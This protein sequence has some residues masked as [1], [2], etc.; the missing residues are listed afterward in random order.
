MSKLNENH[1]G[2]I[3][4]KELIGI[5]SNWIIFLKTKWL[6][7]II[8]S[9]IFGFAGVIYASLQ[10]ILYTA[11]ITFV[12]EEGK[13]GSPSLGNLASLAG[14]FG[15]DVGG[16]SNGGVLSGDNIL[17]YFKSEALA[18]EVLLSQYDTSSDI[19]LADRYCEVY[20]LK[21]KWKNNK[22]IGVVNFPISK[23]THLNSR[24]QDSLL[25]RIVNTI[26]SK[27]FNV[28]KTDKKGSFFE[29]TSVMENE[30]LAKKYSERIVKV[31]VDKYIETKIQRQKA[32]VEKLQLRADS[33]SFLLAK[34]TI[35]S[36]TLQTSSNTIDIN[37]LF[38]T[39]STVAAETTL[40]DKSMLTTIFASVVQNLEVAKFTLSQE[41]P[42]LQIIDTPILPLKVQQ[43]SKKNYAILSS[44]SGFLI[45][46]FFLILRKNLSAK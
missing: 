39:S 6:T 42:V 40:R 41:T 16:A 13:G 11:K 20:G 31:A 3:T 14:Q 23:N 33:I 22:Q 12:V 4:L 8:V 45:S 10:P 15:V 44:L 43:E 24:L 35:S 9:L 46:M 29:V 5:M 28:S 37:P 38:R 36:A 18:R 21:E 27:Q 32:T 26:L 19:S 17:L 2:E 30:N 25:Q 1:S 34:K 7:L